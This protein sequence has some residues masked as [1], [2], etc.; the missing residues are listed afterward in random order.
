VAD[1][2]QTPASREAPFSLAARLKSMC[3]ACAGL[4]AL[5]RHEPNA[6][7]HLAASVGVIAAGFAVRLSFGEWTAIIIAIALVWIAEA[8][9]TAFEILCDIV[10]PEIHPG[11]RV[12]KDIAAGAVLMSAGAA[13][14]VGAL[15]FL[16][17]LLG[18]L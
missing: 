4:A 2:Q 9:N 10:R 7:I 1:E 17:H 14:I 13:A 11:V 6:R 5:V 3:D 16:P 15:V 18:A 12:A 8:L